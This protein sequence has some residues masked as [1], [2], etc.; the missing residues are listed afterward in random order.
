MDAFKLTS[1]IHC[2]DFNKVHLKYQIK[3]SPCLFTPLSTW[4]MWTYLL[5]PPNLTKAWLFLPF[6]RIRNLNIGN[7]SGFPN[8]IWVTVDDRAS[9][10]RWCLQMGRFCDCALIYNP[11]WSDTKIFITTILCSKSI[12]RHHEVYLLSLLSHSYPRPKC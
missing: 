9:A 7:V 8:V 11:F 3:C 6:C 4:S 5:L 12:P 2:V 1:W 10:I